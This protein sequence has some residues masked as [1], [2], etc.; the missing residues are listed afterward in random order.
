MQYTVRRVIPLP[1]LGSPWEASE[2]QGADTAPIDRFRPESSAHHPRTQVRVVHDDAAIE[3]FFR[4][5]D[6]YV[7]CVQQGPNAPV[8]RDS[9]VE[10]FFRPDAGPGYFNFEF[11][12]GGARLAS[13]IR[14]C[15][16]TADGFADF[17]LLPEDRV[18]SIEVHSSLPR[19]VEP[20]WTHAVVWTLCFRI[21]L[22]L[23]EPHCGPLRGLSGRTWTGNFYKCGDETSHPHWAAWS[24]VDELNFHLP[25]C[26]APLRFE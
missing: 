24:P 21:P 11:S 19:R 16:R 2:W 26:F 17:E 15:R 1:S 22:A 14:D 13:Y 3:G 6:R 4:V 25:R 8:C 7:R 23:L 9:C 5:D 12:G 20:E 18:E 10:F